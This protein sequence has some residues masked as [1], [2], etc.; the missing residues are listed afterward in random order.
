V[1]FSHFLIFPLF[2]LRDLIFLLRISAADNLFLK[3]PENC[4]MVRLFAIYPGAPDAN[5]EGLPGRFT[6]EIIQIQRITKLQQGAA[7]GL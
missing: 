6:A 7:P 1:A 3:R 4:P 2:K 5:P